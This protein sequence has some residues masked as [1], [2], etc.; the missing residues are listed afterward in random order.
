MYHH[1]KRRVQRLELDNDDDR[2]KIV[3]CREED[4]DGAPNTIRFDPEDRF[5]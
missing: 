2:L 1:L 4:F 3:F 5:L